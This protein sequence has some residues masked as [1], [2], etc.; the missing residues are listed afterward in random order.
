VFFVG[1]AGRYDIQVRNATRPS[2]H[3][4]IEVPL[5]RTRLWITP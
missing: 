1:P 2:W 3:P 4:D 5:D